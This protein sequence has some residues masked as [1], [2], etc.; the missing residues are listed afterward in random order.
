V[1]NFS[2]WI[3]PPPIPNSLIGFDLA[4]Y[5]RKLD[6]WEKKYGQELYVAW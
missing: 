1:A 3:P 2:R 6:A 5:Y 4:A